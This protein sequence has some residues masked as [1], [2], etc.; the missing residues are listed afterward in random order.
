[1][2]LVNSA[3]ALATPESNT[4]PTNPSTVIGNNKS[5]KD[6]ALPSA[7]IISGRNDNDTDAMEIDITALDPVFS[8]QTIAKET[9]NCKNH[10]IF[11]LPANNKSNL[12]TIPIVFDVNWTSL[13]S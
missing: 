10:K 2:K 9:Q 1:M 6:F 13:P 3:L 12:A 11:S 4:M 8:A 5:V 7:S